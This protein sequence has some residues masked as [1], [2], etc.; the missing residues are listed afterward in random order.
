MTHEE[1]ERAENALY[2]THAD[3]TDL[4][5]RAETLARSAG[6]TEQERDAIASAAHT[7]LGVWRSIDGRRE[8]LRRVVP[9]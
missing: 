7:L 6:L 2:A 1:K 5:G 3:V 4:Q 8:E 9:S